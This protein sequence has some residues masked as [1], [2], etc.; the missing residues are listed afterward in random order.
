M[1]SGL[2]ALA[3]VVFVV[4]LVSGLLGGP[5]A[6]VLGVAGTGLL[7]VLGLAYW[8]GRGVTVVHLDDRGYRVRL[9]RGVGA[10]TA[11]WPDVEDVVTTHISDEPCVV[12]RLRDGQTTT[13]P[14]RVLDVDREEFVLDLQRFL[15]RGHGLRRL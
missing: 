8:L 4:T 2:V 5:L 10:A 12:L 14:V 6:V 9:V 3:A 7:A 15:Q 11:A 1:G 13:V